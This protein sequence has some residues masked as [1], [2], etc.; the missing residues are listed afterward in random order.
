MSSFGAAPGSFVKKGVF[1]ENT[2]FRDLVQTRAQCM[3]VC[4]LKCCVRT[5]FT[6][7]QCSKLRLV[8]KNRV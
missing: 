5:Y 4:S 3:L 2:P 7:L 8:Y 6:A 1:G